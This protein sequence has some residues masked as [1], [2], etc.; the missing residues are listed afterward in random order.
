MS[1]SDEPKDPLAKYVKVSGKSDAAIGRLI[2]V[3]RWKIGR[4]RRGE[5]PLSMEEQ[6]ALEEFTGVTPAQWADFYAKIV[7]ARAEKG[8]AGKAKRPFGASAGEPVA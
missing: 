2:G 1:E 4:A 6:V 3:N 8:E 7:K 5:L